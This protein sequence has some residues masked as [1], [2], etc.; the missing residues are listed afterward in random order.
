MDAFNGFF[1]IQ[2]ITLQLGLF[3]K[4][5]KNPILTYLAKITDFSISLAF[6]SAIEPRV[7]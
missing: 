2:L 3:K 5:L 4:C 1:K 6:K 7:I